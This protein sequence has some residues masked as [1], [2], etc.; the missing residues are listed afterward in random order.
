MTKTRVS[1]PR[2]T[3]DQV[4]KE[5]SHRCARCA[6]DR[7]QLHHIDEDPSNNDPMNLIPLCPNCHL[8]DQHDPTRHIDPGILK[9][10]RVYRDPTI[11]KPQFQPLFVRMCFLETVSD[12]SDVGK[13]QE[14][15]TE[16][17][18]FLQELQMGT[19]YAKKIGAL[20]DKPPVATFSTG[21][22][23]ERESNNRLYRQREHEYRHQLRDNHTRAYELLVEL[24]RFQ[25]W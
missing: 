22:P 11:L 18:D 24:L 14:K 10:F 8:T 17:V 15:A 2:V 12:D 5:F 9:I 25:K 4:L 7:P 13:L 23:G 6:A 21:R 3:S 20:V 19:F 16:L 1:I